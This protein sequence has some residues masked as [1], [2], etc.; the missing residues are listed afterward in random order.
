M[1]AR[2]LLMRFP[3]SGPW[4]C[5]CQTSH[6]VWA[7][8]ECWIASEPLVLLLQH[9]GSKRYSGQRSEGVKG[10][11][12]TVAKSGAWPASQQ[13]KPMGTERPGMFTFCTRS[14]KAFIL[15]AKRHPQT[16][17]VHHCKATARLSQWSQSR[18]AQLREATEDS[19]LHST[20]PKWGELGR[21]I[22]KLNRVLQIFRVFQ[23]NLLYF[24]RI[25]RANAVFS[26]WRRRKSGEEDGIHLPSKTHSGWSTSLMNLL[27]YFPRKYL[28][29]SK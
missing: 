22:Q 14:L 20:A 16:V 3:D 1:V 26:P 23:Q 21:N 6:L 2:L 7:S 28:F 17:H 11:E 4:P 24:Q 18:K 10:T 8:S 29:N 15:Q 5:K 13:G 12:G 9:L 25:C 19:S 27:T